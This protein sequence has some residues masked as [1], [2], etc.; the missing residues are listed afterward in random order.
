M[1]GGGLPVGRLFG[2]VVR[3]S[4]AWIV[5]AAVVIVVAAQQAALA[6]PGSPVLLQWVLG[7]L[8]AAGFLVSVIAHELAHALVGRRFGVTVD[9]VVVGFAGGI[10]ESVAQA[11]QPRQEL[12]IATAGPFL[13]LVLA[14]ALVAVALG[15]GALGGPLTAIAGG[16]VIVGGLNLV[17]GLLSLVPGVPL[18]GARVVRALALAQTGDRFRAGRITA[19]V[20]RY[21]G[22]L[23]LGVGVALAF[24]EHVTEGLLVLAL[25]WVLA[26]GAQALDRRLGLEEL[27]RGATVGDALAADPVVVGPHLT[28]DTFAD[29]YEG[30]T[31]MPAVAVVEDGVVLGVL[32]YRRLQRL[33]RRRFAATRAGEVMA[34]PPDA[35]FLDPGDALWDTAELMDRRGYD[36]LAVV[37]DGALAG[38]LTSRSIGRLVRRR[39]DARGGPS[40]R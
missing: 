23:T 1:S 15:V 34:T 25:G 12:L 38:M 10:G 3:L 16:L 20:G 18:D 22:W 11:R 5:L 13:S 6:A 17:L 29:R 32:G 40:A 4:P 39:L 36:G 21:T 14:L 37:T 26:R 2:V 9:Q 8:V 35:P 31:G 27:L 7:V 24:A 28:I 33:G 30:E 19:R